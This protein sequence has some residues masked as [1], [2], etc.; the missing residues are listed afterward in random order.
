MKRHVYV[1]DSVEAN[2]L[3]ARTTRRL[4]KVI[5]RER[6]IR[7]PWCSSPYSA[8]ST[9]SNLQVALKIDSNPFMQITLAD[10]STH[11]ATVQSPGP[12]LQAR[13]SDAIPATMVTGDPTALVGRNFIES[14]PLDLSAFLAGESSV[15]IS[16]GPERDSENC[17]DRDI[18]GVQSGMCSADL[19]TTTDADLS[20]LESLEDKRINA[21]SAPKGIRYMRLSVCLCAPDGTK[22][23]HAEEPSVRDTAAVD[24]LDDV[25]AGRAS[26]RKLLSAEAMAVLNPLSITITS[27]LSLPGV[28]LET[29]LLQKHVQPSPHALLE[30]HCKPIYAI[31]QPFPASLHPR[32][33]WTAKS[34]HKDRVRFNHTSVFLLGPMNRHSLEEWADTSSLLVE[35]H[36]RYVPCRNHTSHELYF[37]PSNL[38]SKNISRASHSGA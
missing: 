38:L 3:L 6:V 8:F 9:G 23:N 28:H 29:G 34:T 36:D 10:A 33:M 19:S 22:G 1:E 15:N 17:T 12:G 5:P 7:A 18:L 16:I 25:L 27:A 30:A 24:A 11:G 2:V 21:S 35:I 26:T 13:S 4:W 20:A 14:W 37:E 32:I 31:C